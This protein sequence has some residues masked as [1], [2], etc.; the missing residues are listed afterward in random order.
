M[1]A[2]APPQQVVA[3]CPAS[4][5]A[6]ASIEVIPYNALGDP[7]ADKFLPW[8]WQKLQADDLVDYYFPGQR[9]TGFATLVRMFSGD[10]NVALFKIDA[11]GNT[12]D[13]RI[14]GFITWTRSYMGASEVL[15]A[16]VIF[17][18]RWWGHRTTDAC[19]REAFK[20][21]FSDP[22]VDIILGVCP[23]LHKG[24]DAFNKRIGF[25]ETGRITGAHLYKGH[26]CDAVLYEIT[27]DQWE[28]QCRH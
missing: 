7:D 11:P 6:L 24:I 19:A 3:T 18:K 14:P 13:D 22:A 26:K 28:A 23:S 10:A 21:W 17:F 12:W 25:R 1:P 15:I 16:G 5:P 27:R 9:E 8:C 4:A 2:P 20:F